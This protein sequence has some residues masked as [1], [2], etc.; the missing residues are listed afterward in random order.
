MR[1]ALRRAGLDPQ[2][3]AV[4]G[5]NRA[6]VIAQIAGDTARYVLIGAHY[7]HLGSDSGQIYRGA[8][9]NTAAVAILVEVAQAS[10]EGVVIRR[11][12]AEIIPPLSAGRA[13]AETLLADCDAQGRLP[14]ELQMQA[15]LLVG[16]L[17][18]RLA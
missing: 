18:Q 11:A 15:T 4:P 3:Q 2:E 7:D 14:E 5:C 8:D 13:V 17:E 16:L 12:D 6:N 1:D 9:D 10:E